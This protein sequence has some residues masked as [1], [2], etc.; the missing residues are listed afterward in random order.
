MHELLDRAHLA[1]HFFQEHVLEHPACLLSEELW[2]EANAIVELMERF[3]QKV[4]EVSA[5]ADEEAGEGRA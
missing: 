3:Y 4:G 2:R 5:A 1:S